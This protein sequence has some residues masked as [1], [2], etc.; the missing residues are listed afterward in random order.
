MPST[1]KPRADS[2]VAALAP[3]I[4]AEVARLLGEANQSY[5]AVVEWLQAEHRVKVSV[6]ALC[7]W[8]SVHSWTQNAATARQFA[9]QVKAE[10]KATGNYDAATLA[11]VQERAYIMARTQGAD[12]NALATLA[13]IIGDSAKLR[14]KEREVALNESSLNLKLR[15]YEDK[16]SAARA[17]L[18]KAKS[19]GGLNKTTLELIEEQL[20]LL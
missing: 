4:R 13:G 5:A 14:L 7:N 11:L 20:R 1:K 19:K 17:S 3:E 2:K 10:S 12:V 16:I 9:E 18:E 15:Q 6:T 8:Y